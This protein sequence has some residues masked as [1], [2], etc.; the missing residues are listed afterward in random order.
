MS[1]SSS[2]AT[3]TYTS[4]APPSHVPAPAYPEYLAP[5]NDE[6]PVKDQPLPTDASPTIDSPGYIA[7]SEPIKDDFEEDPKMDPI[8]YD[9]DEEEES[10]NDDEEEEH[11]TPADSA[12][13][14]PDSVS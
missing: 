7:D 1:S 9:A 5:S 10:S 2:H 4:E 11:P 3:V 8:E 14:V 6:V 12:L 13:P